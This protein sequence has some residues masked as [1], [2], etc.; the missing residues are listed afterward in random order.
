[1][2]RLPSSPAGSSAGVPESYLSRLRMDAQSK[3]ATYAATL[4]AEQLEP[5]GKRRVE[6][7]RCAESKPSRQQAHLH[8]T[9]LNIL[10][11]HRT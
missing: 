6:I 7:L 10:V 9:R 2:T 1:M 8:P 11:R 4:L 3:A 5:L